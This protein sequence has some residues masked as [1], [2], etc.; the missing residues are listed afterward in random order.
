MFVF[1]FYL[2]LKFINFVCILTIFNWCFIQ[3]YFLFGNLLFFL[4][5]LIMNL[6]L[7]YVLFRVDHIIHLSIFIILIL[8]IE[9]IKDYIII[10]LQ[11]NLRITK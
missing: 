2:F 5:Q 8:K 1:A 3:N 6:W 11:S 7:F 9:F 4:N 10:W